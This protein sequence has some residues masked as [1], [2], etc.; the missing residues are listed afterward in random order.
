MELFHPRMLPSIKEKLSTFD[1]ASI[2][3][4]EIL[5][6]GPTLQSAPITTFGPMIDVGSTLAD[7]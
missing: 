6:P 1:P 7:S 3:E 4:F 2:V 5:Q